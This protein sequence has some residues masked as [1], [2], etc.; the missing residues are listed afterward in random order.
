MVTWVGMDNVA[1]AVERQTKLI[2]NKKKQDSGSKIGKRKTMKKCEED[3]ETSLGTLTCQK[4]YNHDLHEHYW[5]GQA[6]VLW[7][8]DPFEFKI[9]DD[10]KKR[11]EK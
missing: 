6:V 10:S 1:A 3:I 11:K 7:K 9:I 8:R 2:L 5:E 4:A